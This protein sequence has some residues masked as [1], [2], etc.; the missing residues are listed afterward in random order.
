MLTVTF[1]LCKQLEQYFSVA[2]E[3]CCYNQ[4]FTISIH[5]GNANLLCF[6]FLKA[7]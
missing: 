3:K 7:S 4:T 5:M 2:N 1:Q 6:V